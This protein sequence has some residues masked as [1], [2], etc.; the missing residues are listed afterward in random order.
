MCVKYLGCVAVAKYYDIR[1]ST[2]ANAMKRGSLKYIMVGRL[3]KTTLD[4]FLEYLQ[5]RYKLNRRRNILGKRVYSKESGLYTIREA[6]KELRTC[7]SLIYKYLRD[8]YIKL[9]TH[10]NKNYVVTEQ[11]L[12]EIKRVKQHIRMNKGKNRPKI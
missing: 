6:A 12:Q 10:E 1:P 11:Q 9:S 2:V 7:T 5:D 3:R 4:W 8:G